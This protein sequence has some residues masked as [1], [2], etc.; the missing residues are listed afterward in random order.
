MATVYS[1]ICWGGAGKTVTLTIA[2]P[3]VATITSHGLRNGSAIVLSTTG[4]L[5]TGLSAGTTYYAGNVAASTFNLYDTEANA[6]ASGAT[7]RIDTSGTQSGV[8]TAKSDY[9]VNSV[10]DWTRYG[11]AGASDPT[12]ARAYA[13]LEAWVSGRSGASA[14]DEEI[15]EIADPFDDVLSGAVSLNVPAASSIIITSIDGT[16]SAAWHGGNYPSSVTSPALS[17]GYIL[18]SSA[19]FGASITFSTFDIILDGVIVYSTGTSA[20]MISFGAIFNTIRNCF[21]IGGG[22]SQTGIELPNAACNV[23][24]CVVDGVANGISPSGFGASAGV[25][26]ANNTVVN[27]TTGFVTATNAAGFYYNNVAVGCTTNWG[28]IPAGL[29][30]AGFNAGASGDTPWYTGTD[31]GVKTATADNTTFVNYAGRDL[32]PASVSS[33]LYDAGTIALKAQPEDMAEDLRPSYNNG[34][35][36]A[37]DIGA[38]EFDNGFGLP[39]ITVTFNGLVSGSTV[40]IFTTGTTSL[41]ASTTSSG[42]SYS[43]SGVGVASYDYQIFK[44]GYIPIRATGVAFSDGLT[45]TINQTTDPAYQAS[46]G[47]THGTTAS[48]NTS[49]KRFALTTGSTGQ[50]WYSFWIESWR[51][52]TAYYNLEFPL[53]A[54]GPNSFRLREGYEFDSSTSIANLSRDGIQYQNTSGTVTATWAAFLS[55]G[56]PSGEQVRYQQSDGGTTQDA[57]NTG[58]MDELVQIYGDA[59]HGNFDYTGY[60]VAKVQ[61]EGY[62]QVEVDAV[63]L[64]GTL[65]DQLYVLALTPTANTVPTGDPALGSPPTITDHGAS[66]V[67]W[68]AKSFSITI[69]DSVA[70]NSGSD[71]QQWLRYNFEQGGTFQGKDGFNWHDLVQQNGDDF[72][73][74]RGAVYGD[75]GA[76]LKGVRVITNGTTDPHPDF[77]LFTADDGTTFTPAPSATVTVSGLTSGSRVQ[78]YDTA[79][80]AEIYNDIVAATSLNYSEVY[81]VDRTI[82]IRI[83][84]VSGATAKHMIEATVGNITAASPDLTYIAAQSDDDVYVTNAIDGSSVTGISIVDATDRVNINIAAGSVTWPQIYA[85]QVYWLNTATGIQ[86]DFAFIDAP[87]TAN[88]LLTGFKIKNT[89]SPTVPLTISSGYGRD[90]T[91]GASVDL[92]DTTGGTLIFA[93]DHV[94][95]YSSGSGLT[96]GQDAALT[97]IKGV[98]DQ[99]SFSVANQ[100]DANALTSVGMTAGQEAKLDAVKGKTDSLTFTVANNLDANI[101]YVNDVAVTGTGATGSEWGPAP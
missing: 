10:S 98:T 56:V 49:S 54:N 58:N 7:G 52:Q 41:A 45:I 46:S 6:I 11:G 68:N 22:S 96:A 63:S 95:A 23:I 39:P 90:S 47:L 87:D 24:N 75:T 48:V 38:Y 73:T 83:T 31:T 18:K 53:Q 27:C 100:V 85:Y 88:Y 78:L 32:R 71:I 97:A 99:F 35:S 33:A 72:K 13:G 14:F 26:V 57:S 55:A 1:L 30:G 8:H 86:D 20:R 5:P 74:V 2:S 15:C 92:V 60:F 17:D 51:S 93:P 40:R 89:S 4:A 82:R 21:I 67:T 80:A 37:W 42:T 25:Y 29:N 28:S 44:D 65:E 34:G 61:A 84:Y 79:N 81:S 76:A 62:D 36:E 77:N 9:Y 94:V 101:Q 43:P 91:T 69:E 19:G 16:R 59:T 70:G 3:C 12:G 64:Y 66:P 50:N